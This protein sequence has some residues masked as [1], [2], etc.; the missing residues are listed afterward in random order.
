MKKLIALIVFFGISLSSFF[1]GQVTYAWYSPDAPG[2]DSITITTDNTFDN[3]ARPNGDLRNEVTG[4]YAHGEFYVDGS[5]LGPVTNGQKVKMFSTNGTYILTVHTVVKTKEQPKPE[6][7]PEP[8]PQQPKKDNNSKSSSKQQDST[9]S[10]PSKHKSNSNKKETS[11]SESKP[12]SYTPKK[13]K[14]SKPK[15]VQ[16]KKES[17]GSSSESS[18]NKSKEIPK[19]EVVTVEK[20]GVKIP[21]KNPEDHV[22]VNPRE[23]K[24]ESKNDKSDSEKKDD[25]KNENKDNKEDKKQDS[26]KAQDQN[27]QNDNTTPS[28]SPKSK[29][30]GQGSFSPIVITGVALGAGA[31]T[32][33]GAAAIFPSFRRTLQSLFRKVT[34]I[35]KK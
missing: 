9:S 11:R 24:E 22:N 6:P 35:F 20:D 5:Y 8:K 16:T 13:E 14:V 32:V 19:G 3:R 1:G 4:Y 17:K 26:E 28:N 34:G 30:E 25:K 15:E 21:M 31:A 2:K 27:S 10:S 18:T 33:A 12:K 23:A 29:D 7:K